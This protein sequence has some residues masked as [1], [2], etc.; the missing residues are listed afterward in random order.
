LINDTLTVWG[1]LKLLQISPN[2]FYAREWGGEFEINI[3]NDGP[4]E[5]IVLADSKS[6]FQKVESGDPSTIELTKY[7]ADY[8]SA[9]LETTYHFTIKDDQ[10]IINHRWLGEIGLFPITNDLFQSDWGWFIQ[11]E[12]TYEGKITGFNINGERTLNVFFEKKK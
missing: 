6:T 5:L 12:R 1:G 9:E 3:S 10:L 4:P 7:A 11:F 2:M 8:E